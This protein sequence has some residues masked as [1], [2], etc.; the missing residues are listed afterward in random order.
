MA[1]N[2]SVARQREDELLLRCGDPST[3]YF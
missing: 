2:P 3:K 1:A